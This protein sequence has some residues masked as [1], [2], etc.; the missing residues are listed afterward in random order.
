MVKKG[1]GLGFIFLLLISCK[2][3]QENFASDGNIILYPEKYK[4]TVWGIGFE[5]Q[6]DAIGSGN[7]G[8]PDELHAVPHDLIPSER[9]RLA[10]EMLS[11]FRYCRL[12]GGLY[13]RGLDK[14]QKYLQ[15]RWPEQL[16]EIRQM[17]EWA[18]V[19]GVSLEYWSPAPYWKANNSYVGTGENDRTNVLRC[20]GPDFKKDPVYHGDT[21]AFLNDFAEATVRDIQTLKAAGI[22]TSKWGMQNE[23]FT[24]NGSYSACKYY[25]SENYIRAYTKAAKAVR[26]YDPNILLFADTEWGF[27][28]KIAP[29][30]NQKEVADLVDAYCIHCIGVDSEKIKDYHKKIRNELPL[31]P[32]F[33]NE[34][35]YLQ[36]GATPKRCLNTVQHIMN[37]FQIGENP[38]WYWIHALKPFKNSEA[39]GYSLGFWKSLLPGHEPKDI[40]KYERWMKG[41]I[42]TEMPEEFKEME[43]LN[44]M[45]KSEK[46]PGVYYSCVINQPVTAYMLVDQV[47]N[48]VPEGWTKTDLKVLRSKGTDVV[49]TRKME[50]GKISIPKHDGREGDVYGAPHAIFLQAENMETFDVAVGINSPMKIRSKAI[51]LE[52]EAAKMKPGTWIYNDFNWNA[53]GSFVKHMPWDC[54]V[55]ELAEENY[56]KDARVF[57]FERPNG[58][59]TIVVSNRSGKDYTFSIDTNVKSGKWK[60]YRYT[61]WERG[62]NTM[63]KKLKNKKGK[64]LK[65]ALPN[66]S[67]EF[68]EEQ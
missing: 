43:Y 28:K 67:W 38:T 16:E 10:K 21:L 1:I 45:R 37:C 8:L 7:N 26:D 4:Q 58:K 46:K 52:L 36:G 32:W 59:R 57:A 3:Q 22:K 31:K 61:P 42:I 41:D 55:I 60:G 44:G 47:G 9:E 40:G 18:G 39:S 63:G 13:W 64:V 53:V 17:M 51:K 54:K 62:E 20:F 50:K 33:Q 23:P 27:P 66:L 65:M 29:G 6:S 2:M 49:Y 35:E 11:G 68:W 56:N 30:M 15:P 12:A 14:E 19:E 25:K 34:Y 48:Y 5:I 24:N